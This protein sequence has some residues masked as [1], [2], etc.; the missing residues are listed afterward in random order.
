MRRTYWQRLNRT[1]SCG[2]GDQEGDLLFDYARESTENARAHGAR[3]PEAVGETMKAVLHT[4]LAWQ[5]EPGLP[6]GTAI[7]AAVFRHDSEVAECFV[8]WFR[9]VFEAVP[10]TP[11]TISREPPDRQRLRAPLP[12]RRLADRPRR[13]RPG[14]AALQHERLPQ[15]P[16]RWYLT[17]FLAPGDAPEEQLAQD[18]EEA[19]DEPAEPL[20]GSDDAGTPDRGSHKRIFLPSSMGLSMLVDEETKR[21]D[22]AVSWGDYAPEVADTPEIA[23]TSDAA[24]GP[25][26]T[27]GP[28]AADGPGNAS[29]LQDAPAGSVTPAVRED[30]G[31]LDAT[32]A[33]HIASGARDAPDKPGASAAR[34]GDGPPEGENPPEGESPPEDSRRARRLRA[35]G[36]AGP[37]R[38]RWPSTWTPSLPADRPASICRTAAASPSSASSGRPTSRPSTALVRPGR[39][40]CSR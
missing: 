24:G 32:A 18:S 23:D 27:G 17:G 30:G 28:E 7:R 6:Y 38:A 33:A 12:L 21:L 25:E 2:N 37:D 3:Y 11:M 20:H 29:G 39:C 9:R 40:R 15:A 34:K 5:E 14:D 31:P 13:P 10:P 22:V 1:S 8:R 26:A 35:P 4:W 36:C 19:L 16:S